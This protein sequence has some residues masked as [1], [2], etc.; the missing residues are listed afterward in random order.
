MNSFLS[1]IY[2]FFISFL[3]KWTYCEVIYKKQNNNKEL[4]LII[5]FISISDN[6]ILNNNQVTWGINN[7]INETND[8]HHLQE[9]ELD[10][11]I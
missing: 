9:W 8:H 7:E 5:N 1:I 4:A 11:P 10:S 2:N 3:F 6:F